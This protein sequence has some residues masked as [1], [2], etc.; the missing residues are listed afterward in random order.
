MSVARSTARQIIEGRVLGS[1]E[2]V[3][4]LCDFSVFSGFRVPRMSV[5]RYSATL[6]GIGT[7]WMAHRGKPIVMLLSRSAVGGWGWIIA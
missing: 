2:P 1:V 7:F 5:L 6:I 4:H 3:C